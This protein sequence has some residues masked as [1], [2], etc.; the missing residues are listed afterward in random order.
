VSCLLSLTLFTGLCPDC[1]HGTCNP[2]TS[3]CA[4]DPEWRGTNCDTDVDE[5]RRTVNCD[6]I[7]TCI[8]QSPGYTCGMKS[9][10]WKFELKL[11]LLQSVPQATIQ[12]TGALRAMVSLPSFN[13]VTVLTVYR[14]RR[15]QLC[16]CLSRC[17]TLCELQW[18]I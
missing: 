15:V 16:R 6:P 12:R 5:C 3:K 7:A 14:H 2:L 8:N 13:E 9:N 17:S 18:R 11:T 4:C 10:E 1:V